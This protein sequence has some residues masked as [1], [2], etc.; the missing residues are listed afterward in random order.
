MGGT[1]TGPAKAR[2]A[3]RSDQ[4]AQCFIQ[5]GT[6]NLQGWTFHNLCGQSATLLNCPDEEKGFPYI[7][8][9]PCHKPLW[10]DWLRLLNNLLISI[11]RLLLDTNWHLPFSR[12]NKPNSS[13]STFALSLCFHRFTLPQLLLLAIKL[14]GF[15]K[16][17]WMSPSMDSILENKDNLRLGLN[18]CSSLPSPAL[19]I[20]SSQLSYL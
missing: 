7:S 10:R 16:I 14:A 9:F 20:F 15:R 8:L 2:P 12:P 11:V 19:L 18:V 17:G 13:T 4:V 1:L 6:E 3:M 5:L